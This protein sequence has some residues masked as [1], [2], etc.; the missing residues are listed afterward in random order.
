ML[1]RRNVFTSFSLILTALLLFNFQNCAPAGTS[2]SSGASSEVRIVDDLNKVELQF[3]APG[4]QVH[5]DAVFTAVSGLCNR[6]HNGAHLRWAVMPASGSSVRPL[7]TGEAECL[8]GQFAVKFDAFDQ[9][10]CEVQ[11]TLVLEGDWGG[12]A[13]TSISRRCPALASKE[14][15]GAEIPGTFCSLELRAGNACS[16]V[17]YRDQKVVLVES[18]EASACSGMSSGLAGQ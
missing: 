4:V 13:F 10:Q 7:F 5:S 18:K 1:S 14:L 17:C 11:H 15:D 6:T 3:P 9:L 8:S 2:A 12:S 16:R